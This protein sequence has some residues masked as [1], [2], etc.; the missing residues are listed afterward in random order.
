MTEKSFTEEYILVGNL[1]IDRLVQ[2]SSMDMRKVER[3]KA[4]FNPA[5]MGLIAVSRRNAVTNIVLDG[6]HRVQAVKELTDNTGEVLCQVFKELTLEEEAQTF[7]DLNYGNQPT[8]LDKFRVRVVAGDKMAQEIEQEVRSYGWSIGSSTQNGF[9]QCV[10]RLETIYKQSLAI[11]AEPSLLQATIMVVTRAW[12]LDRNGC[13][14]TI[15]EGISSMVAEHGS[16]LDLKTLERALKVYPGGPI[17]L[18]T[19]AV[20][21]AN[22]KKGRVGMAVAEQLTEAYNKGR[23]TKQLPAWRRR[24]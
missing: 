16:S 3:I 14:A 4:N 7:L 9:L 6:Q 5:A 2:R 23:K 8:L 13:N 11:D 22:L 24:R 12:G 1:D 20:Q 18:H 19:D 17:G 15:L 21:L 10:G